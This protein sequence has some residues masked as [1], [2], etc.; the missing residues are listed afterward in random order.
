MSI[1]EPDT[2][3]LVREI[4]LLELEVMYLEQYLLSLY[5]RA[6][7]HQVLT[8]SSS[9]GGKLTRSWNS[10]SKMIEHDSTLGASS[11]KEDTRQYLCFRK[12]T[13]QNS[14]IKVV[15]Q[16]DD[17]YG[18]AWFSQ[19]AT[20]SARISSFNESFARATYSCHSQPLSFRKA[21]RCQSLFFSR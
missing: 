1:P 12:T 15:P 9:S 18:N 19:R 6:F 14:T 4:A 13:N 11:R 2:E 7:D 8:L 21:I 10:H 16:D 20:C 5:R 17:Q 3:E